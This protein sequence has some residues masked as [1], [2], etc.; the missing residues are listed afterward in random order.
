MAVDFTLYEV[1][2]AGK[3]LDV[4]ADAFARVQADAAMQADENF[5]RLTAS[6]APFDRS[7]IAGLYQKYAALRDAEAKGEQKQG[8]VIGDNFKPS[9]QL[10]DLERR[11]LLGAR[12]FATDIFGNLAYAQAAKNVEVW[13]NPMNGGLGSSVSRHSYLERMTGRTE[14]GAKGTDLFFKVEVS[15]FNAQGR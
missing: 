11:E 7:Y 3:N 6:L 14:L 15:G 1:D 13:A 9:A 4:V 2:A 12:D 10:T 8:L 5:E